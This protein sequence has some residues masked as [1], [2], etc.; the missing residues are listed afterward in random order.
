[1]S[2]LYALLPAR[3]PQ[4]SLTLSGCKAGGSIAGQVDLSADLPAGQRR[5]LRVAAFDALGHERLD[6][7]RYPRVTARRVTFAIPVAFNDPAGEWT[8]T[9][10]DIATGQ[11][12]SARVRVE[13]SPVH[14]T[15]PYP[16]QSEVGVTPYSE[17]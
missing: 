8:I 10:T 12:A 6:L 4:P 1:M 16:W 3:A 17:P 5:V 11:H 13:P 14:V 15:V 7:R 2:R 9:V